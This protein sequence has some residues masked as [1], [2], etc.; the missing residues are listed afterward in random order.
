[1]R[2]GRALREKWA[3][4][5]RMSDPAFARSYNLH[6][7]YGQYVSRVMQRYAKLVRTVEGAPST[8]AE[9]DRWSERSERAAA[10]LRSKCP[11]GDSSHR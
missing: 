5:Q 4:E 9:W 10:R 1:M 7:S 6:W 3:A 11:C 2:A 8:D